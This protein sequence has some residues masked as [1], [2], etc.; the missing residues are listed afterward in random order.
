MASKTVFTTRSVVHCPSC[1]KKMLL[2]NW[3]D[4]CR[5]KHAMSQKAIDM[6]YSTLK[7]QIERSKTTAVS[8]IT[9][10]DIDKPISVPK[11]D[12]FSLKKF[13]LIKD[14]DPI[15]SDVGAGD[16]LDHSRTARVVSD[17]IDDSF[18]DDVPEVA[19]A[20]KYSSD[21]GEPTSDAGMTYIFSHDKH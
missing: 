11:K 14:S 7:S 18:F 3:K 5:Q 15:S 1:A 12:L 10:T 13:A 20:S 4:H 9:T 16:P 21:F 6:A 17:S 2:K 8:S 19:E